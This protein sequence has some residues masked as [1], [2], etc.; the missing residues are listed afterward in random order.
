M[1]TDG[2]NDRLVTAPWR[3]PDRRVSLHDRGS[4][5][6]VTAPKKSAAGIPAVAVSLRRTIAQIGVIDTARALTVVNQTQGFDCPGCAWPERKDRHIAEFCE[7]GAKAV[8]DQADHNRCTPDFFAT[9]S[10]EHLAA[11]DDFW[12]GQRG[13][14]THPMIRR[15]GATHYE[16]IEWD[17]ALTII[18]D[19]LKLLHSP[20]E[21][22]FYTSGRTS[23]EAA[24]AYQL[25]ARSYGTNNLPDCSN[26]CHKP[27]SVALQ[28]AIGIGKGSVTF[29]DFDHTD[30]VIVVGQNPGSN[31]PRMLTTLEEKLMRRSDCPNLKVLFK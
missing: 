16:Q 28:D 30:L 11:Q 19:E 23:N 6:T 31:H 4:D 27:T 13:R 10:I 29:E 17:E 15:S 22:I 3:R 7:N 8:A 26:M 2:V 9:H 14:L 18:S 21:A 25:L 20:D 12:L 5:V 24:F 1:P